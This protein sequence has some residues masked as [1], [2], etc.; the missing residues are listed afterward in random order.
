MVPIP[1]PN[2]QKAFK[3][4]N[5]G[6]ALVSV[7]YKLLERILLANEKV[8]LEDLNI[9]SEL[10]GAGRTGISSL[11]TSMLV[12]QTV[13]ERT[14]KGATGFAAFLDIKKA[15]NSVWLSR[16]SASYTWQDSNRSLGKYYETHIMVF[17]AWFWD[18]Q[19]GQWFSVERG[20]HKGAPLS[21]PLYQILINDL[22]TA[23]KTKEYGIMVGER[24]LYVLHT[25]MIWR[26]RPCISQG[27]ISC[28]KLHMITVFNEITP[29]VSRKVW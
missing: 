12:Q 17:N 26:W 10:Q 16:S 19:S 7:L 15:F 6:I 11:H 14:S 13:V 23:L 2:K 22:V 5:R 3:D 1:K 28:C 21:M 8:W 9:M 29:L 18:G 20:V 24:I 4:N 27:W 25:P